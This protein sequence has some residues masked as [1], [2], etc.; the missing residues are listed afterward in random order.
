MLT[1]KPTYDTNSK[2]KFRV[3]SSQSQTI[4]IIEVQRTS[5]WCAPT[6]T[7]AKYAARSI[8]TMAS[9]LCK[10]NMLRQVNV[11]VSMKL[12]NNCVIFLIKNR[13]KP[14]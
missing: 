10:E 3:N 9:I 13:K 4:D 2:K 6:A 1:T 8:K 14:R 12:L 5:N 7:I 11:T